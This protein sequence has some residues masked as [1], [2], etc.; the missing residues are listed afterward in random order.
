MTD[1]QPGRDDLRRI[2]DQAAAWAARRLSGAFDKDD[3]S[4]F[5]AWLDEDARHKAAL[6]EYMAIA[7]TS[8]LAG[9]V[10]GLSAP[11]NDEPARNSVSP[12]RWWRVGAPAI[13]ASLFAA[14]F[15][16][17]AS[18]ETPAD[19]E[20]FATVRGETRDISLPDGTTVT[21]NTDTVLTFDMKGDERHAVL[22]RG[23][24]YFDVAHDKARPFS[25][26]AGDA[27]TTV[28]GTSFTVRIE[29]GASFV[30]VLRGKVAVHSITD[31][32]PTDGLQLEPGQRVAVT[33]AG[34]VG[35]VD[36]FDT[37]T[38]A[39]W[40]YGYLYF[41]ETPLTHVVADLNRY[42]DRRVELA[43]DDLGSA[44]VSGRVE[45]DDQD[46]AVRAI[47]VA[48]SLKVEQANADKIILRADD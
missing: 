6:N 20:R 5:R 21:L 2:D 19:P 11:A 27:R 30:G 46:V 43:D 15:F 45:L 18:Y 44:P 35:G 41:D 16:F 47:S 39:T 42:F 8:A 34:A 29:D 1:L 3:E 36:T 40:R 14:F 23:E 9:A 26:D 22:E 28:L 4:R 12:R 37:S 10:G 17:T 38:A 25:V 7:E 32:A 48:L 31:G 33:S 13:A 24:A